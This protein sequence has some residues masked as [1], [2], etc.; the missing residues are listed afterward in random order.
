LILSSKSKFHKKLLIGDNLG[1]QTRI[2]K[3]KIKKKKKKK[4]SNRPLLIYR[5]KELQPISILT[6]TL[7]STKSYFEKWL[8]YQLLPE[9]GMHSDDFDKYFSLE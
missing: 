2:K 8:K 6:K 4:K 1:N 9:Y 5:K 7:F 3:R